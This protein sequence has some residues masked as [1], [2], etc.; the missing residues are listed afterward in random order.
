MLAELDR[1]KETKQL[2][3]IIPYPKLMHSVRTRNF[4]EMSAY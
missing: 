2:D 1:S 4:K 3:E